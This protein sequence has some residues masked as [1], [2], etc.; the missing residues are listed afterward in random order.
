MQ[1]DFLIVGGGVVGMAVAY[2]LARAGQRVSV[3]DESDDALR[4][5]RGNAGLTWMQGKGAGMP[6]YGELSLDSCLAWPDFAAELAARTG[7]DIQHECHGGVDLCFD[8]DEA[9]VRCNE[10]TALQG[11]SPRLASDFRWQYLEREALLTHLPGLGES[12]HG[13]TWS[14]H[15]GHCNPLYLLRALYAACQMLGV[16]IRPATPVNE[17]RALGAGFSARTA[18]GSVAAERIV[19]AAGLGART[20]A[21]VLGLSGAVRPVRGQMLI[22]ERRPI[23]PQ[24]PTPQIRQTASG[25]YLIGDS[26]EDAG[27]DKGVTLEMLQ[28]LAEKA[29]RIYPALRDARL[30]RAWGALR[31]MTPDGYPLYEEST[32]HP[33]AYNLNCHSGITLAALHAGALSQSLLDDRLGRDYPQFSG[34]RFDVQ[35]Y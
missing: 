1:R 4:A 2:G 17:V 9:E 26:H 13:G 29:V 30:V 15:D 5:S 6:R 18:M 25:G 19:I 8:A 31:V 7:V 10:Y 22:T 35:A 23:V 27:L 28:V 3:L 34:A 16:E 21:P 14:P 12:V 20:L 33:G 32:L 24:L 11:A